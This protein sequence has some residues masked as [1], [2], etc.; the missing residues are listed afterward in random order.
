VDTFYV[1]TAAGG[2]VTDPYHR[3]EIERALLFAVA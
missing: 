3:K 1:R 2:L